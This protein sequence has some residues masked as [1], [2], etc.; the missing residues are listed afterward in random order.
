MW[1]NGS[2]R[3]VLITATR[4]DSALLR[5]CKLRTVVFDGCN[6][7]GTDFQFAELTGVRFEQCDL[8]GAQWAHAKLSNVVFDACT[9]LDMG[10]AT[11][12]AGATVRGPG[13]LELALGLARESGIVIEP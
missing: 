2:F 6:L 1:S 10:G 5:Y 4:A 3:D 11:S 8:T 13:A 7:Q 9:L 12:L